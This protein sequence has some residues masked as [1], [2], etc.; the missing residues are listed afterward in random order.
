[1][2]DTR[3]PGPARRQPPG[4]R[5]TSRTTKSL[6]LTDVGSDKA[7]HHARD[8]RLGSRYQ[9]DR[10]HPRQCPETSVPVQKRRVLREPRSS[11]AIPYARN[12]T[13]T[14]TKNPYP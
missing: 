1:P 9:G 3:S 10:V 6:A 12:R 4:P 11:S 5:Y 2:P 13:T 8:R 14:R 7:G